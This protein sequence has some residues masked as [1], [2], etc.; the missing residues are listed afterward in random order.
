MN[1]SRHDN[2]MRC[3][4]HGPWDETARAFTLIELLVVIAILSLLVS[5]L[6][7]SLRTALDLAKGTVCASNLHQIATAGQFYSEDNGEYIVPFERKWDSQ[8]WYDRSIPRWFNYLRPYATTY[9]LFNCPV[10]NVSPTV[11][12]NMGYQT[13]VVQLVGENNIPTWVPSGQSM[14]G[15]SSNYA[16][17]CYLS[18]CENLA[19]SPGPAITYS[20]RKLGDV[21]ALVAKAGVNPNGLLY[22]M[23]GVF[24]VTVNTYPVVSSSRWYNAQADWR[25][26]HPSQTA[27]I[28][29]LD[30]HVETHTAGD[31]KNRYL[32]NPDYINLLYT[33]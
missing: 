4:K 8:A 32:P 27:N 1:T 33:D 24:Q 10:M 28:L 18:Y 22:I 19:G 21:E 3:R 20:A 9:H 26:V 31:I 6:L 29:Y 11:P 15:V 14:V 2:G 25:Y 5:L 23:D 17:Q 12:G 30:G 16:Y 7:P 13:Q